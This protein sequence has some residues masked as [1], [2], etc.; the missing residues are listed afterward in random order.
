MKQFLKIGFILMLSITAFAQNPYSPKTLS[1][2]DRAKVIDMWL[3]ER[4]KTVLPK[5]MRRSGIDMWVIISREYNE[6]PV[7][8]TFLPSTWQ[9]ARRTTILVVYDPG[10]G[11]A[12]ETYA[13]A[14][15]GVGKI[16]V[17]TWE[18]EKQPDQW[19][20]L[21]D[22]I[23]VKNPKKIGINR[24]STHALADGITATDYTKLMN[25]RQ[26]IHTPGYQHSPA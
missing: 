8:R 5:V 24:S 21:A 4:V 16:F 1:M 25:S 3:E 19:K 10:A 7:L 9:S 11:K 20:A 26:T 2:R 18:R 12:I 6:D 13:M 14:R 22:F 23:A 17:K 15:Y